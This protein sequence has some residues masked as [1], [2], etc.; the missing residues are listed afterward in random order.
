VRGE[1]LL[2][3]VTMILDRQRVK[4]YRNLGNKYAFL[5]NQLFSVVDCDTGRVDHRTMGITLSKVVFHVNGAGNQRV[6]S[7]GVKNVHAYVY[8][9]Y[10]EHEW[11]LWDCPEETGIKDLMLV[12][13]EYNPKKNDHFICCDTGQ[14]IYGA[15]YAVIGH[16]A[17]GKG[18]DTTSVAAYI[19]LKKDY[20]KYNPMLHS[21]RG[22][23]PDSR[24]FYDEVGR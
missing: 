9:N 16:Y 7:S 21:F 17:Q 24:E 18:R 8:G 4:V 2:G 14:P 3:K 23:M 11:E 15:E 19:D 20:T 22:E 13:V 12:Y 1:V 5:G 10:I 6:K